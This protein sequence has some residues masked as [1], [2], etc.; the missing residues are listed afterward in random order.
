MPCEFQDLNIRRVFYTNMLFAILWSPSSCTIQV[1]RC[2]VNALKANF[3]TW[4]YDESPVRQT[5][6]GVSFEWPH[7]T[8]YHDFL[9]SKPFKYTDAIVRQCLFM[10][11]IITGVV[12]LHTILL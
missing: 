6:L 8:V 3:S 9:H 11:I 12:V 5:S 2:Y 10:H 1:I 7:L 4:K